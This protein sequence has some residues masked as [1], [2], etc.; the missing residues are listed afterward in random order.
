[1]ILRRPCFGTNSV[2]KY[3]LLLLSLGF[4]SASQAELQF[5][6]NEN[7]A[8]SQPV[9]GASIE[10]RIIHVFDSRNVENLTIPVEVTCC[11]WVKGPGS[12]TAEQP[13]ALPSARLST[14]G[15]IAR[16]I[17]LSGLPVGGVFVATSGSGDASI[18]S[19]FSIQR[20]SDRVL[21]QL[22]ESGPVSASFDGQ[23]IENLR[24]NTSQ[25]QRC[26]ISVKGHK[27]VVIRNVHITH[28]GA[29]ICLNDAENA[30]I[31]KALVVSTSAPKT[32]PHCNFGVE[33]CN[34]DDV[35]IEHVETEKGAS[36]ILIEKSDNVHVSELRCFDIRGPYPRGS[37]LSFVRSDHGSL[38]NFYS[39]NIQ[40]V[41]HDLDIINMWKSDHVTVS[42]GL[43]DGSYGRN[44]AGVIA[45]DSSDFVTVSNVDFVRTSNTATA[46]ASSRGNE[47]VGKNFVAENIRVKDTSCLARD[48]RPP[49]S[50]SLVVWIQGGADHPRVSNY[51]YVNHCR[52]YAVYCLNKSCRTRNGGVGGK[53]D[54]R[55]EDFQLKEPLQLMFDWQ[56]QLS[57]FPSTEAVLEGLK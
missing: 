21:L 33:N 56:Q 49:S 38:S 4:A 3:T 20:R 48:G 32:G 18:S 12:Q 30:S 47:T 1:M 14:I 39:K 29:G 10:A 19:E 11:E 26:A 45:D 50:G 36:G 31:Q 41:S 52:K 46:V 23:V 53:F 5:S 43:V 27:D 9:E 15:G 13:A 34:S 7:L 55:E 17:D 35:T 24:I 57:D 51:Q 6:Y 54:I 40:D 37:C 8:N 16:T 2:L 44:A 28:K 42:D 22:E 25:K